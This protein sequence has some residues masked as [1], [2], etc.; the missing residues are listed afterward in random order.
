MERCE[1]CDAQ[2]NHK[3]GRLCAACI[4]YDMDYDP[5]VDDR[6][7]AD[8]YE[9]CGLMPNGQCTRAGSEECD[10]ECGRLH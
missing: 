2:I 3:H 4:A 6:F 7:E 9:D 5:E 1:R 10:W 8:E